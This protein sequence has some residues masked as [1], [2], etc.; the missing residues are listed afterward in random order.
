MAYTPSGRAR[1][2]GGKLSAIIEY[3]AGDRPAS[4]TPTPMR[5]RKSVRKLLARPQAAVI[6]LQNVM[7]TAIRLRREPRSA[8]HANGIPMTV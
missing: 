1:F 8:S 4:P 3:A 7:L 2:S 5:A 6:T